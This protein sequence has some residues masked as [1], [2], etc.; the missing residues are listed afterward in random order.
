MKN[1]LKMYTNI[2]IYLKQNFG[3]IVKMISK[4]KI[5]NWIKEWLVIEYDAK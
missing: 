2:L 4:K 1:H 3:K 5:K